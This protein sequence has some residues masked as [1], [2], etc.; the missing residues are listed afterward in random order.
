MTPG[1]KPRAIRIVREFKGGLS[2]VGL[3][4]K[5]SMTRLA[6]EDTVRRYM[7]RQQKVLDF[8]AWR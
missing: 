6:V 4:R 8:G 1:R 3:A 2:F 7:R 5:Y